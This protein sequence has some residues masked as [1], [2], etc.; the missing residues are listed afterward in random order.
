MSQVEDE[1]FLVK[2]ARND[3]QAFAILFD[4]FVDRIY[5]YSKRL[6]GDE[7]LAQDVTSATFVKAMRHL[8]PS[9]SIPLSQLISL[10]KLIPLGKFICNGE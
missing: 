1:Q 10:L 9:Q 5:A 4:R 8:R 6:T 3:P 7:A 2:R